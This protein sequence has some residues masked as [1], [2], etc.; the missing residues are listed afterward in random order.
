VAIKVDREVRPD[1][2]DV[3][4]SAVQL[5][6]GGGGWPMTVWL[7]PERQPFY[8][9]TYFP[10]RDGARGVRVGFRTLLE[11]LS[12]A[13]EAQPLR[14]VTQSDEL[15]RQLQAIAVP[16]PADALPDAAVLRAGVARWTAAFDPEH[17]GFGQAPKFPTPAVLE[18]L[19]RW[20]RRT[21]DAHA[22]D[23]VLRTLEQ[24]AAGGIHDQVGGGFHRYATDTAWQVPHFEKM[25]VDN[26]QLAL[27]YLDA[28]QLTGRADFAA[29]V[30]DVLDYV[31]RDM[32]APEGGFW[33]A[34]DADSE[35]EEGRFFVWTPAEV[36]AAL[37]DTQA[38][39]ALAYFDVTDAG[40]FASGRT[41]LHVPRP[42]AETAAALGLKPAQL[43]AL[44]EE[45]R[46]GLRAARA[47]RIAPH[48]DTKI[49]AGTNGLMVS[50]YARAG[51]ALGV[52]AWIDRA[53]AAATFALERMRLGGKLAHAW[54]AGAPHGEAFLDDH[55]FL[56]A[57]LVDLYEATGDP[58]WLRE[59]LSLHEALARDFSDAEHGGFFLT[60]A[61][62]DT[63]LARQKP[64]SDG[65][66]PSGNAVAAR[67]LLRLAELTGD[68]RW[69]AQAD[70]TLR[71][72]GGGLARAPTS[73]PAL[74]AAIE[75]RLDRMKE[76]VI[77]TPA[78]ARDGAAALL[79]TVLAA[80]LPN[81]VLT[82]VAEGDVARN[83]TLVPLVAEKRALGG[84]ATAYV[85]EQ[86]VCAL[87]T[88][89]PA[90]LARQLARVEPLP[91]A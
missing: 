17:G 67:T 15:A 6:T 70:A 27:V 91:G 11:R 80:Y 37:D 59:A 78:A 1:V 42:L 43:G 38:A 58:R 73:A 45:A 32:T 87:P 50:A 22:R 90:V 65:A 72:V 81:A 30:R 9:G 85:C 63:P 57:G 26:A 25:L 74:L 8:G 48:T 49:V 46:T 44:V 24:M 2:D 84:V 19:L 53:R 68:D 89:D 66:V 60:A 51:A 62:V 52:P 79:E 47:S 40:N 86:R 21:G 5:L 29:V 3:Y 76:I 4:M 36:R 61:H 56:A 82:V 39:A 41:I 10:P 33:T 18:F 31:G 83:A 12:D 71:A 7:T 23:M 28:Y 14:I 16:A 69:R 55:A 75:S 13:F 35:G 88:A 20:H 77:V 64:D 34:T 54:S